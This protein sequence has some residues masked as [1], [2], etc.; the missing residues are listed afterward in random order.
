V[1]ELFDTEILDKAMDNA[2]ILVTGEK[3]FEELID[4]QDEVMLPFN[5]EEEFFDYDIMIEY[6]I[7]TEEYEKCDILVK[8]K[9]K[10]NNET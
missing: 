6:Y 5:I 3:T 8:L 9:N 4:E 7:T 2:F 10:E 1:R